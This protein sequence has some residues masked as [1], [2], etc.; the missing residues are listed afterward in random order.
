[1][2][3]E[4]FI[5]DRTYRVE[6]NEPV[7]YLFG[8]LINGKSFLVKKPL[9]PY[10][11]IRKSDE[12]QACKLI[13]FYD[14]QE[15][16]LKTFD[17]EAVLKVFVSEPKI[18][19]DVRK[20]LEDEKIPVYEA[21]IPLTQ[22]LMLNNNILSM[23]S[24]HA[25]PLNENNERVD[26]VFDN[27]DLGPSNASVHDVP[28]KVFSFDLEASDARSGILYSVAIHAQT[29]GKKEDLFKKI[30][31]LAH[32]DHKG[33][34]LTSDDSVIVVQKEKEMLERLNKIIY[35]YDPDIITG[36]N[37]IDFDLAF[38]KDKYD[39]YG[40]DF[41][42]ARINWPNKLRI[43][44]SFQRDS[45]AE[46]PGRVVLDGLQIL[47][48]SFV[49]LDDYKLDTA[50]HEILGEKKLIGGSNKM[51]E[52][53]DA[54]HKDPKKLIAYNYKDALLVVKIL[55]KKELL[56]LTMLR[57]SIVGLPPNRVSASIA[58]LDSL[59]IREAHKRG[60]V[61]PTGGFV[62]KE[63]GIMGG[64]VKAS[65]PGIYE[66][67]IVLDFKSLYPSIMRTFNIDPLHHRP[68]CKAR[69]NETLIKAPNDTCFVNDHGILPELLE[70]V[71]RERDAAK[72]RKDDTA[73]YAFKI[74]MNSFFGAMA[75]PNCRFFN[76]DL[77]NA[78]THFA[79]HFIKQTIDELEAQG[80]NVIYGDTDSVFINLD[81]NSYE[82]AQ[83]LGL[84]I[85]DAMNKKLHKQITEE[86]NRTSF[87]ELEFEK[88]Y[89]SFLMPK[90]RGSETG[91]KKRYAGLK[92]T[93]DTESMDF[94]GLEFVRRDW[95]GLA[96]EFQL[97]LLEKVF[98]KQP[99]E[100][101]VKTFVEDLKKGV[102]DD[103]LIYRKA[104]RKDLESYTKTTPPHVKAA[105]KIIERGGHIESPIIEYLM[106]ADG[107]EPYSDVKS[108]I[109]Y[110]HYVEKQIKPIADSVL[111]FF[112]TTLDDVLAGSS[113]KTLF[114]Y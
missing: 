5:I 42:W 23:V 28:L 1:M 99:V 82:Q 78:I 60:F 29:L 3:Y 85:Q 2:V 107:P 57:S 32:N 18:I 38:L 24:I 67:V 10:F 88:T 20:I 109:D 41:S 110:D 45:K 111:C 11:Y 4:G 102:Y 48:A 69:N 34:D 92:I 105:R 103:L 35:E 96:K 63:Q 33:V 112:D 59:Y 50:A 86:F 70:R 22:Q 72:K 113:Q 61:V 19:S 37:V 26:C 71:W 31:F 74:L 9:R 52:I 21:D 64:Y 51:K 83:K 101:Y 55:Q 95:T 15:S 17:D 56:A 106:T 47:R 108:S 8:R 87:L 39:K 30:L 16:E 90:T 49:N 65:S 81:V 68:D 53:V 62:Q 7:V 58:S 76:M 46:V 104:L 44:S 66:W 91:S 114:G 100:E 6:N 79:Q 25:E 97:T 43:E 36:W 12:K 84:E 80:H 13:K 94:T 98:R 75:S 89:R 40:V 73:S 54:Y 14:T 93:D 27:P 77:A